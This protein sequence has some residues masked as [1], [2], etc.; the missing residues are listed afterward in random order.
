LPVSTVEFSNIQDITQFVASMFEPIVID[1]DKSAASERTAISTKFESAQ[2]WN[3]RVAAG[4]RRMAL[5]KSNGFE[6]GCFLNPI[7]WEFVISGARRSSPLEY[8]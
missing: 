8:I 7:S 2:D 5:V 1:N 3:Y 6:F 4:Q